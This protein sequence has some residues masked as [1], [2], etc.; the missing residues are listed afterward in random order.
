[1]NDGNA[2]TGVTVDSLYGA[3]TI[4][5][6]GTYTYT[7]DQ[8]A[9]PNGSSVT[10]HFVYTLS[11]FDGD[12]SQANMDFNI[13]DVQSPSVLDVTM[14]TNTNNQ[15][16]PVI[17]TFVD[18]VDPTHAFSRLFALGAQGQQGT[19]TPDT[20]FNIDNTHAFGV[21]L[22]AA[23]S[24]TKVLL[25]DFTIEGVPIFGQATGGGGGTQALILD[26]A[27]AGSDRTAITAVL[28]PNAPAPDQAMTLSTDG[29]QNVNSPTD[30][31]AN[32][33]NYY[34]GGDGNDT[35][36]GSTD[37]DILN[38]GV[39][40]IAGG[41][42]VDILHAG[43]GNDILVFDPNDAVI[44][45]GTGI[46]VLRIDQGALALFNGAAGTVD[47][48]LT[49]VDV[50]LHN[51][52]A[53]SNMEVVLITDD[54]GGDSSRGTRITLDAN[55][56]LHF[57]QDAANSASRT[58]YVEGNPGDVA[59]IGT[60]GAGGWADQGMVGSYHQFAETVSGIQLLLKVEN[61][62]IVHA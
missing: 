32:T 3:L 44:D 46:D 28:H 15:V 27:T 33:F 26:N 13:N 4:N 34:F 19:F 52:A 5:E 21:S 56:V 29:D 55:D 30:V 14:I 18:Q 8:N 22:E 2:A 36:T 57:T 24:T 38:G 9:A 35:L 59:A 61:S 16:Q 23:G 37:A 25:T 48:G 47:S 42:S 51:N 11:D 17:L 60:I 54:A 45:G 1:V 6:F 39:A 49:V 40:P 31:A 20:G 58:L 43:A 50:N 53:I 62:V 41:T 12:T 7:V 10:D